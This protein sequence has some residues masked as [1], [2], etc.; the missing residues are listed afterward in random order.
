[1]KR[2]AF[3]RLGLWFVHVNPDNATD[4]KLTFPSGEQLPCGGTTWAGDNYPAF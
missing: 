4:I 1:L 3:E 2:E